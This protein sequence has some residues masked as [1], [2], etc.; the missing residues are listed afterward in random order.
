MNLASRP[1]SSHVSSTEPIHG[2]LLVDKSRGMSSHDVVARARRALQTRRVGHTGTLDPMATG[3]LLLAIGEATK[4]VAHLT[5]HDKRYTCTVR[6]GVETASLDADGAP[7][8]SAPVPTMTLPMIDALCRELAAR[9]LQVPPVVSAIRVDG[10]RS[11]QRA[12]RGD[13]VA[14]PARPVQVHALTVDALRDQEIDLSV[15]CG[16]GFYVR[17]LARDLAYAIGT[18]GHL[19][20]LRRTHIGSDDVRQAVD[21]TLLEHAS[22]GDEAARVTLRQRVIPLPHA[23]ERL[24]AVTLNAVGLD[25]AAHGRAVPRDCVEGAL[26]AVDQVVVL[27]DHERRPVALGRVVPDGIKIARGFVSA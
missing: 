15:H 13:A 19:T 16:K 10:E 3:L 22:R 20:E 26:P 25:H 2:L 24:I 5:E 21:A 14:L 8:V 6:L 27:L 11:Y 9:T 12:R 23:C 18:V 7:T 1:E 17:A 4:L